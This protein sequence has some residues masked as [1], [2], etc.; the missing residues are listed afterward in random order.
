MISLTQWLE[1]VKTIYNEP[2][3]LE[4]IRLLGYETTDCHWHDDGPDFYRTT[5]RS[6]GDLP[7]RMGLVITPRWVSVVF[8]QMQPP[9]I[10]VH[11]S[12]DRSNKE[13][14]N[15]VLL[16]LSLIKRLKDLPCS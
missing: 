2:P 13:P 12:F 4:A 16:S 6:Q 14:I 8:V 5:Y 7:G 1:T 15:D 9:C 3:I 10:D 11:L